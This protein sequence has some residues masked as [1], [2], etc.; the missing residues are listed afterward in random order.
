MVH[1]YHFLDTSYIN[2]VTTVKTEVGKTLISTCFLAPLNLIQACYSKKFVKK[3]LFPLGLT[4][5]LGRFLKKPTHAFG[6]LSES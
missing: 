3:Y 2:L 4:L 1:F 6:N 5:W